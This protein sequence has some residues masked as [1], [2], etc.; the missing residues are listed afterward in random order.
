MTTKPKAKRGPKPLPP[1][2]ARSRRW[3]AML[4]DREFEAVEA[5]LAAAGQTRRELL[6]GLLPDRDAS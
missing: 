1:G 3:V 5:Q 2:A 6:I 4:D